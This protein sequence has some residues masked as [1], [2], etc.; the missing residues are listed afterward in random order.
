MQSKFKVEKIRELM[1]KNK[2]DTYIITKFDPHFSEYTTPHFDTVKY[3]S[4]FTG[5]NGSIVIT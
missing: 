4:N 3:V 1:K 5:S 2:I